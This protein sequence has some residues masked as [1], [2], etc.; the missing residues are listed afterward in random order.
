MKKKIVENE[1]YVLNTPDEL[2]IEYLRK[3]AKTKQHI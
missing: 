1:R 3:N 2:T